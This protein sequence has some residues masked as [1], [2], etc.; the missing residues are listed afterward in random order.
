MFKQKLKLPTTIKRVSLLA[1]LAV[2]MV[3]SF[4][5]VFS[6]A[7]QVEAAASST[8]N[9]QARLLTAAG[10]IVPDGQYNV[11]FKL[12]D[13]ASGGT[14][15]WTE[16]RTTSNK[17]RV[18][19][20]Y[21]TVNLGSVTAFGSI[22]WD[23]ELWLTMNIGG[24]GAAS[25]DG[26]MT[27]RLKL[28]AVPHAFT[29]GKLVGGSG[30]NTTTL[31]TGTPSGNN[32]IQLPAESGT[33]CIQNSANCGFALSSG[34][35][36]YIQNQFS[37]A[38]TPANFWI[39]GVGRM[40]TALQSP[41]IRATT[42]G[43]T[44][45]Q[46]QNAAGSAAA[47][48]I[49][50]T[51]YRVSI[52]NGGTAFAPQEALDVIGN[53]QVRDAATATKGYRLRTSGGGL[54]FE[55][56]GADLILSNWS[57]AGYT[58]TQ[59]NY[60]R[61]ESGANVAHAIGSWQ[62]APS[63]YGTTRHTIDGSASASVSFNQDGQA[64]DFSV[65]GDTDANLFFI[66]GST[67]RVGIGTA[68]PGYKLD[69][70]GDINISTGSSYRIN[71]VAICTSTG[72]TPAAG[73][74]N[75]IQNG[76]TLQTGNF[77]IQS[78]AASSVGAIIRGAAS[79]TSSLLQLLDG[80]TGY[81][82]AQF[83]NNGYLTLGSDNIAKAG[84]IT[85][86]DGTA[87]NGF[88]TTLVVPTALTASRTITLPDENGTICIQSSTTCGFAPASGSANYIQNQNAAQQAS[89][90]FWISGTGRTDTAL[91]SPLFDT[92]TA[93]ALNIG[94]T[95]ATSIN[96]RKNT[97][98]FGDLN[99]TGTQPASVTG[100]GTSASISSIVAGKGGN[101]TGTTGQSA[102][103]GGTLYL[104]GG[105]GGNASTGSA[106]GWG[107]SVIID[108]GA[109]GSGTGSAGFR[110][111]VILQGTAGSVGIGTLSPSSSYK[112][113]VA[114]DI[115]IST[116][117]A[118]RINGTAICTSTG[119]TPAAG[120]ANYIQNQNAIQQTA[121][122]FWISGTGRA[123]TALQA[124]LFDTPTAA[125]LNIGT[126]N[127]TAIN[128]NKDTTITGGLTQSGGVIDLAGNGASTIRTTSGSLSIR[129]FNTNTLTLN[130]SGAGT[131]NV[132]T[133]NTTTINLGGGTDVARTINVGNPAS[134]TANQT[135]N[136]G[137][138][139]GTSV[140]TIQGGS[141]G[142]A[143]AITPAAGGSV[144]I[145]TSGT[146]DIAL[147]SGNAGSFTT[148]GALTLTAG[149]TS[150]WS[151]SAGS[152]TI[153]AA[154][155][156]T[157]SLQTSGAGTV[158][159]GDVNSTTIN[160]GR[161]SD[162]ARTISIGTAGSTT[163]QTIT[164]GS[165]STTSSTT[166]R[167]GTGASAIALTPGTNGSVAATTTGTGNISLSSANAGSFT[168][169]SGALTL[170]GG[171]ASTWST[172]AGN[173][174]IQAAT[175]NT[176]ILNTVG[177]GTIALGDTNSTTINIGRGSDI[178]RTINIGTGGVT[179]AQTVTIGSTSTTSS[180]TIR[181]GTGATAIA[182]TPG[183]NGS[184]NATTT[185]TGNIN[186]TSAAQ[187]IV[188]SSTNSTTAFQIQ[189]SLNTPIFNVDTTNARIGINTATP[190]VDLDVVGIMQQHGAVTS[191]TVG[192]EA[193]KWTKIASCSYANQ[194]TQCNTVFTITGGNNGTDNENTQATVSARVKQQNAMGSAPWVDITVNGVARVITKDDIKAVTTVNT[195]G[196]TTVELWGRITN[197][198][199]H[200]QIAPLINTTQPI[201]GQYSPWQWFSQSGFQAAL[202]AG[203]QTS[204][205]Y[206]TTY[207]D[208]LTVSPASN[209]GAVFNVLNATNG[210]MLTVD[211]SSGRVI[212]GR[213]DGLD[214]AD[215]RLYFGDTA[216]ANNPWIGE[217]NGTDSDILQIQGKNGINLS[218][219][220][221]ATNVLTLSA[222]GAATFTNTT[223]STTAFQV[224]TSGGGAT[225]FDVDT[226]NGRVGIGTA[227]PS[228]VLHVS[229]S[230]VADLFKVTDTTA[231]AMD[232]LKVADNGQTTFQNRTD[233][234]TAFRV[235]KQA[236]NALLTVDTT[237]NL[238]NISGAGTGLGGGR[239]TFG[240]N[241][242]V[243]IGEYGA[244]DTDA[245]RIHGEE[246]IY[247]TTKYSTTT[248]MMYLDGG[249]GRVGIN[250]QAPTETLTVVGN[251]N[252]INA[253]ANKSYRWRTSGS[254]LD[255]EGGGADMY[256]SVWSDAAYSATQR[257]YL[258]MYSGSSRMDVSATYTYFNPSTTSGNVID[259]NR[260]T[261]GTLIGFALAGTIQGSIGVSGTTVSYNAFT[262]SHYALSD[263]N[264][265]RGFL[266][267]M[268]GNNQR[269]NPNDYA[270]EPFYGIEKT[271][272]AN[273]P[274][275]LGSMLG[276]VDGAK[277]LSMD[278]PYQV[279]SVGNGDMWV[280]DEGGD[281][282]PGDYLISSNLAG[283]AM[284]DTGEFAESNIVARASDG[285]NWSNETKIVNGHKVRKISVLF[286]QFTRLNAAGLAMGVANGGIVSNDLTFNG[287]ATFNKAV[288]FNSDVAMLGH[289]KVGDNTAGTVKIPAGQ[290]SA[291]VSFSAPYDNTPKITTGVSDFVDVKVDNKSKNGFTVRIPAPRGD[292]VYVD[293][294]AF[295]A[296]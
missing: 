87:S 200:W 14:N 236:G 9:F 45:I 288:T 66:Q 252:V 192:T 289:I 34:G 231:T 82:I 48:S 119:C 107:G 172:S 25:W 53:I 99:Q 251:A 229:S 126:T 94:T 132:G 123:D 138:Q 266:V 279:M 245:L 56:S 2:A 282:E 156:N 183:T 28:T 165:T 69:V 77:Y 160:I 206:G 55:A 221:S 97:N 83:S 242:Y 175:T 260:S 290:T 240:D 59:R 129:A 237:S 65:Q 191:N 39:S 36:N 250:T 71:G 226:T 24:T 263:E 108:G 30:S 104:Q 42:N 178:A 145:T 78:A 155:A 164:I 244:N 11:E 281:I 228:A 134:G 7:K 58:G 280:S 295:E 227:A 137:T 54:D 61:L 150:T 3:A 121:S 291:A 35:T 264:I 265:E 249:T 188:K 130:T 120:S 89:S 131:V 284:K 116:G 37:A 27:P 62:F 96:L 114:G 68:T 196:N 194:W 176:L 15:V 140:T 17:V 170:T 144:G 212:I 112:L 133:D 8:I 205:T 177:A 90:N 38:Q 1:F 258:R 238:V 257:Q 92:P 256:L 4:I 29:A 210:N 40:D 136:V 122:N 100:N 142:T 20:G 52:G 147:N 85:F 253:A 243:Y 106:N 115:N 254:A 57:G 199:E 19:N 93:A 272:T 135:V 26:E 101:T 276:I 80:T 211:S 215:A 16:T 262:G 234:T 202:P 179:T 271:A 294:T 49:D 127:A 273:D 110:G 43:T 270:S 32:T 166:I 180:T 33:L 173:L 182:L 10:G 269:R 163:A 31:T 168:T 275:V 153:Q 91:Q 223:N 255:F 201:T 246:E 13:A 75:Y 139:H 117:S 193:N 283:Y 98:I 181:G 148:T 18:I 195:A 161:G 248:A 267:S 103:N 225:V 216:N 197:I 149:A 293:W 67:D 6:Q 174:T 64:T 74:N 86:N 292:D 209:T 5:G 198:Y 185:G 203:T 79:Q 141:S 187:T 46:F 41:A 102:G 217:A 213:D 208:T 207:A 124:P 70:A 184:I 222:T 51:N 23:Q 158:A 152:L 224:M 186:L 169:T 235:L 72:C 219:S 287:L 218:V 81:T 159:V 239:L 157:L 286:T 105:A 12:Y 241:S 190:N 230:A 278:N 76:T 268:T 233:S 154:G 22:N 247:L 274:K 151:T 204:A 95:N 167:G 50:T 128:L 47:M 162:I 146:G 189:N 88:T 125:A 84:Q 171:A 261:A 277:G 113:D 259:V 109:P 143:V 60:L 118:Y 220:T 296:P 214:G 44:A 232:V 111:N 73:S 21:L 285:V 63:P